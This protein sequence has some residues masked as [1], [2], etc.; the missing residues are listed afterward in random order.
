MISNYTKKLVIQKK[1][2]ELI[3]NNLSGIYKREMNFISN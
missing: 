2:F 1:L 3:L